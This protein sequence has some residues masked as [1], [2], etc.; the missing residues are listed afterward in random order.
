MLYAFMGYPPIAGWTVMDLQRVARSV[1]VAHPALVAVD[2]ETGLAL[3]RPFGRPHVAFVVAAS[4]WSSMM[5]GVPYPAP[6]QPNPA[7]LT[8]TSRNLPYRTQP[9]LIPTKHTRGH[10]AAAH[11]NLPGPI[12]PDRNTSELGTTSR[13]VADRIARCALAGDVLSQAYMNRPDLTLADLIAADQASAHRNVA[14]RNA[15]HSTQP[16]TT[17]SHPLAPLRACI[18]STPKRVSDNHAL[19]QQTRHHPSE[20]DPTRTWRT[21][22]HRVDRGPCGRVSLPDRA[23]PER[24]SSDLSPSHINL[25][26]LARP[27]LAF[28]YPNSPRRSASYRKRK[29]PNTCALV[30][31]LRT[32]GG[33]TDVRVVDHEPQQNSP[34]D[35]S[36]KHIQYTRNG[37][38][39]QEGVAGERA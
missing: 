24:A 28:A 6:A 11:Q 26:N 9:R 35:V 19:A 5:I 7:D 8:L 15:A 13:T 36:S 16:K 3:G 33:C 22:P 21:A 4:H 31:L 29:N 38:P 25:P 18:P 17:L 37:R 39:C 20:A 2:G 1:L 30:G 14:H 32:H 10:L 23:R 27:E 12:S 34:R